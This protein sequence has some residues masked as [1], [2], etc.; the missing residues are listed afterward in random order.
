MHC[1]HGR[2]RA[3]RGARAGQ[4]LDEDQARC[5]RIIE[6]EFPTRD[7][8]GK[9][10]LIALFTTI[11]DMTAAPAAQIAGANHQRWEHETGK[12]PAQDVPA[13]H[14]SDAAVQEPGHSPPGDLRLP[15]HPLCPVGPDLP[16]RDRGRAAK[17]IGSSSNRP[18]ASSAAGPCLRPA[19]LSADPGTQVRRSEMM[20]P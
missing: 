14:R 13:G 19:R 16:G 12:C 4:D 7:S 3:H 20:Y 6:Y 11:T 17:R 1:G 10:E 5:V 15:A 18:S 2:G 9:G 8:Q